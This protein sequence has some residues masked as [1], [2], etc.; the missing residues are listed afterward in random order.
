MSTKIRIDTLEIRSTSNLDELER[1]Y[2]QNQQKVDFIDNLLE[3]A[4]LPESQKV[5]TWMIKRFLQDGND[6]APSQHA[7]ILDLLQ[8]VHHWEAKLH[9]LQILQYINIPKSRTEEIRI[10]LM[11]WIVE[12]NKFLRAWAYHGLYYLQSGH[13]QYKEKIIPLLNEVYPKE[14]PS[15][16]ARIRKLLVEDEWQN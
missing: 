15:V 8:V 13:P 11:N 1:F 10:L 6:I 7:P 12:K 3:L 9:L 14:A 16:K 5:T 2:C 4:T